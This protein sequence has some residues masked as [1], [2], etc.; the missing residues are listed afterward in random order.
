MSVFY[1]LTQ[2]KNE[3]MTGAYQKWYASVVPTETK[4]LKD[5]SEIIQRNCS[6]KKVT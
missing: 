3:K 4:T 5:I 6:M 2:N 1:K